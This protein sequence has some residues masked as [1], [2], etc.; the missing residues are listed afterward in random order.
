MRRSAAIEQPPATQ[1]PQELLPHVLTPQ[2]VDQRVQCRIQCG[3]AEEDASVIE[4]RALLH[5]AGSV[6]EEDGEG[7]QPTD[8]ED[9]KDNCDRLQESIRWRIGGLLVAGAHNEID[10]N[11]KDHDGQQDDA[12]DGDNKPD[13][14]SGVEGQNS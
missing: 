7:R 3:K 6:Q 13:V 4:D 5:L 2:G 10:A 11:V 9:A 1:D 8:D 12:K 14:V